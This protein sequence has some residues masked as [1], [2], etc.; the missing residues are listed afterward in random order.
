MKTDKNQHYNRRNFI[1]GAS[2][3]TFSAALLPNILTAGTAAKTNKNHPAIPKTR[4]EHLNLY[5]KVTASVED[6]KEAITTFSGIS[7]GME[8]T[9]IMTPLHGVNVA[10]FTRTQSQEDGS[11]RFMT[12]IVGVYH[13][14]KT[15]KI[16]EDWENPYTGKKVK[17]WHQINGPIN[18]RLTPDMS[19]GLLDAQEGE[20]GFLFPVSVKDDLL[21]MSTHYSSNRKNPLDPEE[22]PLE[23]T[24]ER[25]RTAEFNDWTVPVADIVDTS[26]PEADFQGSWISVRPW[27]PFMQMGKKEGTVVTPKIVT[28]CQSIGDLDRRILSFGEKYFPELMGAPQNWTTS[29]NKSN[30]DYFKEQYK[31]M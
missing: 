25:L 18:Y 15:G 7:Y 26:K 8:S 9:R 28:R 5:R 24:G 29:S 21:M 13:D 20:K 10:I 22:W 19:L 31:R 6:N 12:N 17:A 1:S 16:L 11:V 30:S 2:A 23:Y 4:A 14:L 27:R 3:L